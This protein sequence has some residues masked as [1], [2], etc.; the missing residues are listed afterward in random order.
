VSVGAPLVFRGRLSL[1]DVT[2]VRRYHDRILLRKP[3]R[4][5]VGL[6]ATALAVVCTSAMFLI[7][8]HPAAVAVI[9]A[10]LCLLLLPWER[11]WRARRHCRK[12][13]EEYLET[14]VALTEDRVSIEN[15]ALRS[16]FQWKVVGL[17]CDTPQGLLF[18]DRAFRALFWLPARLFD[19][20][21]PREAVLELT[22]RNAVR[23]RRLS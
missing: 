12:H 2:H 1:E 16:E 23:V 8:P 14:Q 21:Q 5:V 20:S 11:R 22:A 7:G 17:V 6:F 18:C 10:W 3:L 15:E 4:W 9:L 19:G 13:P